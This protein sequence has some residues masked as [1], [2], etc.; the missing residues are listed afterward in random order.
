MPVDDRSSTHHTKQRS[1]TADDDEGGADKA[2]DREAV[3]SADK[4]K[5]SGI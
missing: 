4:D 1:K 2:D 5:G 3:E